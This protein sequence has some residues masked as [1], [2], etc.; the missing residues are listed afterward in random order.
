VRVTIKCVADYRVNTKVEL[1]F[2]TYFNVNG[3][4]EVK[5]L[6]DFSVTGIGV[7]NYIGE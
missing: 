4:F 6:A 5:Y 7:V 2:F 3:D 1:Y